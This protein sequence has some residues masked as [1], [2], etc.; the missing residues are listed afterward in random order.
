MIAEFATTKEYLA[1]QRADLGHVTH[2]PLACHLGVDY[3]SVAVFEK[4]FALHLRRAATP[5]VQ[6]RG[7]AAPNRPTR[8]YKSGT[9]SAS[10]GL[11]FR[12]RAFFGRVSSNFS[13]VYL[14]TRL[15]TRVQSQVGVR[16]GF[17]T[18]SMVVCSL[19]EQTR[20]SSALYA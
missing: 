13:G 17:P 8:V 14:V 9:R 12:H 11:P 15:G 5:I 4:S 6:D 1:R 10:L 18:I 7:A 2:C 16:L 3:V 20:A 19:V